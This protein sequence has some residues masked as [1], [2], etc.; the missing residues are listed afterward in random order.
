MFERPHHNAIATILAA[1]DDRLLLE[2]RCFLGG[3]TAIVLALDEYRDSVDIAFFCSSQE[4]YRLLRS[5]AF[6]RGLD[7]LLKPGAEVAALRD[8]RADQ[9]GMRTQIG[10]GNAK[11]RFEIVRE[12]RIPISG[13]FDPVLGVPVLSR[14]DMYCER[15]LAN[16]DHH[17]DRSVLNR[18]IIDLS[19]MISRFGPIPEAAWSKAKGAYGETVVNAYDKAAQAIHDPRWLRTCMTRMGMDLDLAHEIL[20]IHG[21]SVASSDGITPYGNSYSM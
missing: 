16:A 11:V 5:T 14:D 15:L 12:A 4:G 9:Y 7:G 10:V 1:L 13:T 17:A 2:A 6:D 21:G 3:G 19:M 18:D 8:M 20:P